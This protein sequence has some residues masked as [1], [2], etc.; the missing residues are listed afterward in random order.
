MARSCSR[1]TKAA[2]RRGLPARRR[3]AA[4]HGR[5][6][7]TRGPVSAGA[8]LWQLAARPT[9]RGAPFPAVRI[10]DAPRFAWRGLMLDSA[11]HFQSPAFIERCIDAMALHKLNVLH[12]HLTDDQALAPR[13]PPLSAADRGRRLARAR[14]RAAQTTSIRRP[15]S[16]AATAAST[17]KDEVRRIVAY[18]PS[19]T[20]RS[21]RRSRC[22]AMRPPAIVA[23]PDA[24]RRRRPPREVPARLGHLSRTCSTSTTA[25]LAFLEDVL[26]RGDGALPRAATSTSAATR[27]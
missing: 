14:R 13:D 22:R 4:H 27:R 1:A 3:A 18:A 25:T 19:A 21:C 7:D 5:G 11:R 26:D 20:S 15:A 8:T 10:D 24:R 16:R 17:R 12:W 2:G 6:H 9:G 23:Y